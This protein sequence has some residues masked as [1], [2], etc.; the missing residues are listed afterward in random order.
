[1]VALLL[2]PGLGPGAVPA[3]P[4]VPGPHRVALGITK[5][6]ALLY[7]GPRIAVTPGEFWG[8]NVFTSCSRCI[9]SNPAVGRFLNATPLAFFREGG[10]GDSCNVSSNTMYSPGG[11]ASSPC[12]FDL[13]AFKTWCYSK[14]P[15]CRSVVDLPGE[16]NNSNE[17]AY[18][19]RY[20]VLTV[21]FQPTYWTVGNEPTGWTHYGIP[22]KQ[23]RT[24]DHRTPTPLAYAFDVKAAIARVK[25]VDPAAKFIGIQSACACNTLWLEDVARVDGASLAM[26][27]F[28][29]YPSVLTSGT[30]ET[31]GQFY[32]ALDSPH[33]LV[34]RY[35]QVRQA[36]RNECARCAT[37][38]I[39]I[40]EYN[41]GPG[42]APSNHGG[43]YA[44][45][46]FL[47]ASVAQAMRANVSQLDVY[48]LQSGT[49]SYGYSMMNRNSVLGPPGVLMTQLLPHL[50]TGSV[51]AVHLTTTASNV[52]A[53]L[54]QNGTRSS[55]LI[56]NADLAHSLQLSVGSVLPVGL[57]GTGYL[58]TPGHS[59]PASWGAKIATAYALPS[60][61]ILLIDY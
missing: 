42:W 5:V 1:M 32:Q 28:H 54:T 34:T 3:A 14:S 15:H 38:P 58:W 20:V 26:I 52:W 23:W 12:Q 37:L 25:A 22:W 30:T 57:F 46:V 33:N 56:V 53:V 45:A 17:D 49:T 21:G 48:D 6:P 27:A 19:A 50:V 9:V 43:S 8:I 40:G 11:V 60:Q 24:T 18:I 59:A 7:G 10:G 13:K 61:G 31:L 51:Y 55:L 16:N 39:A 4:V 35:A 47:A 44:N 29:N 2:V 36:I 41:A